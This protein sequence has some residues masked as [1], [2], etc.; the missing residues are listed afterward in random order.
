MTKI[1][2]DLNKHM[3]IS[4]TAY[5]TSGDEIAGDS[6]DSNNESEASE[7]K[8]FDMSFLSLIGD[9]LNEKREYEGTAIDTM[10]DFSNTCKEV[11]FNT[12]EHLIAVRDTLESALPKTEVTPLAMGIMQAST[13]GAL[14]GVAGVDQIK[15][16]L[17]SAKDSL[18]AAKDGFSSFAS[19]IN[20]KN[21]LSA[22][23]ALAKFL[24]CPEES[25]LADLFKAFN[26]IKDL[27]TGLDIKAMLKDIGNNLLSPILDPIKELKSKIES[28][29]FKQ[30]LKDAL[31]KLT[32]NVLNRFPLVNNMM[33]FF[34]QL[35]SFFAS[36]GGD[37]NYALNKIKELLASHG[38]SLDYFDNFNVLENLKD[39]LDPENPIY[40]NL[41]LPNNLPREEV[42]NR[43]SALGKIIA[44]LEGSYRSDN[45]FDDL[46]TDKSSN[47]LFERS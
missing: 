28:L 29:D 17:S 47:L 4:S 24:M 31:G 11:I 26:T 19:A 25:F 8:K 3:L 23:A 39:L 27:V 40:T 2:L 1:A 5:D 38:L 21:G 36:A 18:K 20:P 32:E 15:N 43:C 14:D 42:T 6:V 41:N 30:I 35:N 16:S 46:I 33:Q 34:H 22:I 12:N 44:Q 45:R 9:H 37:P 10:L 7:T 13:F